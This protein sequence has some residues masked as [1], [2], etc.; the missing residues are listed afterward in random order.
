MIVTQE[1]KPNG[2][3]LAT[4]KFGSSLGGRGSRLSLGLRG[5]APAR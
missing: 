1:I 2:V 5:W 3:L 4:G